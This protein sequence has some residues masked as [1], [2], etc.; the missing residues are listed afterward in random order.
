MGLI[1][2]NGVNGLQKSQELNQRSVNADGFQEKIDVFKGLRANDKKET[3]KMN[4]D[5]TYSKKTYRN[6]I[7]E[8][9]TVCKSADNGKEQIVSVTRH[10]YEVD[11]S[12]KEI[13]TSKEFVDENG[14]GYND[15]VIT[16]KYENGRLVEEEK[17]FEEDI[18]TDIKN[19]PWNKHNRLMRS[20]DIG[21]YV[22]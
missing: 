20:H 8:K 6:G 12:G 9:E 2:F 10:Y 13:H 22:N 3:V 17:Y 15:L 5:G 11:D 19:K 14:D 4:S 1:N 7:L 16:K 21:I 18:K